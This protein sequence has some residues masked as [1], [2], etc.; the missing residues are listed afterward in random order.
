[1]DGKGVEVLSASWARS[2]GRPAVAL[3]IDQ[4]DLKRIM[5][6]NGQLTH[7]TR[8]VAYLLKGAG[9]VTVSTPA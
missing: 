9:S 4:K 1:V 6:R 5:I 8:T 2:S 7:R 3:M